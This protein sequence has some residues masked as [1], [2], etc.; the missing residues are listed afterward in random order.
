[1]EKFVEYR[2]MSKKKQKEY[3]NAVRG[4]FGTQPYT[5]AHKSAKDYD[6]KAEKRKIRKELERTERGF[7]SFSFA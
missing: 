6:R 1:M 5:L 2:K 7:G 3:N 4:S